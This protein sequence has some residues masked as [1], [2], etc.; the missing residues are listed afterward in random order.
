MSENSLKIRGK[1]INKLATKI[2][3]LND[4]F[5]LL[6]KVDKKIFK[7]MN[8]Q[9]GEKINNQR[10]GDP[11]PANNAIL[12][13]L[14][15]VQEMKAQQQSLASSLTKLQDI[16]RVINEFTA[17]FTNI[18]GIIDQ[19]QFGVVDVRQLD[20]IN[21]LQTLNENTL[22]PTEIR[23]L[24]TFLNLVPT[25]NPGSL[26]ELKGDQDASGFKDKIDL[27]GF[28]ILFGNSPR[29]PGAAAAAAGPAAADDDVDVG[30]EPDWLQNAAQQ[31][32]LPP[33]TPPGAGAGAAGDN[34]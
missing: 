22:T 17:T 24:T 14:K 23:A 31:V 5:I 9:I 15:K 20:N 7:K 16:G 6:S 11:N 12:A 28:N 21:G 10:G 30:D 2:E 25:K 34:P 1:F 18:K 3:D 4:N 27:S 32:G 26:E 29:P 19:I 13:A 8:N 33:A